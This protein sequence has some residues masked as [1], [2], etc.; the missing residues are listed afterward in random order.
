MVHA[1]G[2]LLSASRNRFSGP[3]PNGAMLRATGTLSAS[4]V[5]NYVGT[6]TLN[7]TG[8]LSANG[9]L[10]QTGSAA[11]LSGT[12]TI[13]ASGILQHEGTATLNGTG[14]ISATGGAL[15]QTG[16]VGLSG[17]G[18]VSASSG[19][20]AQTGTAALSGTG[21]I[22][23]TTPAP[24]AMVDADWDV[25]TGSGSGELDFT[26][27]TAPT[28]N[29]PIIRYEYTTNAGT[30]W[31]TLTTG[32][33]A[34]VSTLSQGGAISD[35]Q[36]FTSQVGVRA[37]SAGGAGGNSNFDTV[38]AGSAA[39]YDPATVADFYFEVGRSGQEMW[40]ELTGQTTAT[41]D[42]NVAG[43]IENIGTGTNNAFAHASG[44]RGTLNTTTGF[45]ELTDGTDSYNYNPGSVPSG[46]TIAWVGDLD[47]SSD[48]FPDR[49]VSVAEAGQPDVDNNGTFSI[50]HTFTAG[51]YHVVENYTELGTAFSPSSGWGLLPFIVT[52]EFGANGAFEIY[53]NNSLLDSGTHTNAISGAVTDL[54]IGILSANAGSGGYAPVD[55][56]AFAYFDSVLSSADRGD[57]NT[58]L[59]AL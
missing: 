49:I 9:V 30:N 4:G 26:I 35:G 16:S 57:L 24:S 28:S 14:T 38:T 50:E 37:V 43:E 15:A 51:Q 34:T 3:V 40:E 22:A 31:A 10:A 39:S 36:V 54:D 53:S 45:I 55:L 25:V 56:K 11:G 23:T 59:A 13:A 47:E 29:A 5:L 46:C 1:N 58:Y 18:T 41:T 6:A 42:G 12:G 8:T 48:A 27:N 32:T 52:W 7:G 21:T 17:T 20:L 2:T 33:T 19:V 44:T